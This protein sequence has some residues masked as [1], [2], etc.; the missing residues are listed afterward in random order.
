MENKQYIEVLKRVLT[1]VN[2]VQKINE[3][4]YRE[5]MRYPQARQLDQTYSAIIEIIK[6]F[7][8]LVRIVF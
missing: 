3:R 2:T 4:N 1:M 6:I 7:T 8:N 5:Q